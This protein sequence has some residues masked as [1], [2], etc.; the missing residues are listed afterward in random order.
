M[1]RHVETSWDLVFDKGSHQSRARLT[2][3]QCFAHETLPADGKPTEVMGKFFTQKGWKVDVANRRRCF[4]PACV[5]QK[6]ERPV[7]PD[8][9]P[10]L[11]I[12]QRIEIPDVAPTPDQKVRIRHLLDSHFDDKAGR[13]LD[14]WTDQKIANDVGVA[15]KAV[16]QIRRLGW[17]E[18]K[19]DP[20]LLAIRAEFETCTALARRYDEALIR[21]KQK[22][23]DLER[24]LGFKPA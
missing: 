9:M 16:E 17:G 10:P 12:V 6:K 15:W 11:K 14:E 5:K 3:S 23:D 19:E 13:Y 22:I 1:R 21:L 20:A 2:C 24:R 8:T 18:L 4:C 7:T